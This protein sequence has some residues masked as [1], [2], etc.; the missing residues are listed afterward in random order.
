MVIWMYLAVLIIGTFFSYLMIFKPLKKEAIE[1]YQ[2]QNNYVLEEMDSSLKII[3]EYANSIAYAKELTNELERFEKDTS[4]KIHQYDLSSTLNTLVYVKSGVRSIALHSFKAPVIYSLIPPSQI[5]QEVF[6]GEWYQEIRKRKSGGGFS[7]GFYVKQENSKTVKVLAYSKNFRVHD[8]RFTVT[9]FLD[10]TELFGKIER[11]RSREFDNSAWLTS[12]REPLFPEQDN[13]GQ[14]LLDQ[15]IATGQEVVETS[16]GVYFIRHIYQYPY[17]SV[18]FVTEKRLYGVFSEYIRMIF[19]FLAAF[20][21]VSLTGILLMI[22]KITRPVSELSQVMSEAVNQDL[23][24]QLN[25]NSDDEIGDLSRIFN[26]M[27][28]DLKDYVE[29]LV[30]KEKREQEMRFGL[31]ASQID[32]HFVCNTLNTVNYLAKQKRDEDVIVVST[33]LSNILRDRLRLKD[34]Q[35]YDTVEQEV[36]TVQRYLKIQEYRYGRKV[37][38]CWNVN[39][40]VKGCNIPK[41]LLQPLIENSLFH[42]LADEDTGEIE[43]IIVIDIYKCDHNLLIRVTDSGRGMSPS[44]LEKLKAEHAETSLKGRGIGISGIRERLN[45]LYHDN[46]AFSIESTIGRGTAVQIEI[47]N[48][49]KSADLMEVERVE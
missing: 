48:E 6:A 45:I 40:E 31:L 26:N 39:Q 24:V 16:N 42:G 19:L 2:A 32:P 34:F 11:F 46:Y 3:E 10:Y 25:V 29:R 23:N 14:E 27:M 37:A 21:L 8:Q 41:N 20:F 38:V 1:R 30:E 22:R 12:Q 7:Q 43:G 36:L 28:I 18:T 35:I 9:I 33:A 49:C 4:N 15:L 17:I 47:L 44:K 13:Q 5:E